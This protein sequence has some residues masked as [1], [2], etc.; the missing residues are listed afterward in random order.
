LRLILPITL[1]C[2]WVSASTAQQV[3][4]GTVFDSSRINFIPGVKVINNAGQFAL[5]DSMGKYSIAVSEKDSLAFMY[6]N[7]TTIK[8]AVQSATDPNH[9]DVSIKV[10]YR[11]KYKV[12]K[13]VIVRTRTYKEDS[14]E[15]RQD[16]AKIFNYQKPALQTSIGPSG[17][18]G[19]DVN[20]IINIF[21]FKRNKRL[22]SF[23][24]RLEQAEQE[25]YINY[26]FNKTLVK[27][28]T[29]LKEEQLSMFMIRYRPT[30]EFASN[31]DELVFNQYILNCSYKY[32]LELL[33]KRD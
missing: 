12:L 5:T 28:I 29:Q 16:Y 21:R 7:K 31:A 1:L 17:V 24:L 26:R 30:Y 4:S 10:P 14:I 15:N 2:L 18:P 25:K 33:K 8:F 22:K 6:N 11:G 23:Q 3:I 9:F 27:R 19:A 20:E 32:K 13:E